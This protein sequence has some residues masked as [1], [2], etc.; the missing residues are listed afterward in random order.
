MRPASEIDR[1]YVLDLLNELVS[2][3]S[4]N[5]TLGR[6][7]GEAA[8][9][10]LLR[11]RLNSVGGLDVRA[12]PVADG[13]SNVIAILRGSGGG[14]SLILNGHM[15]TVGVDGMT[16][17]PFKPFIQNGWMHGRGACDMKGAL[18]AMMGTVKSLVDSGIKLRGNLIF[19][20]VVDEEYQSIGIRKLVQEYK[21]DAAIVGEPTDMRVATAHKGFVWIEIEV[22]GKAAHGSVPEKGVD[23][24]AHAAKIMSA[25][26]KLQPELES[27]VHP[28]LGTPNMHA[29]TV[30][31]GTD[32]SIIPDRCTLRL[33]RRTIPGETASS[34]MT[35]IEQILK[36][37]KHETPNFSAT[38][39]SPFDR[40]PLETA[41]SEGIVQTAQR[42]LAANVGTRVP[43]IGVPYWTDAALLSSMGSIPTC[44][45]GPGDIGVAHSANEYVNLDDVLTSARVYRE[46]IQEY[47]S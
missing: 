23:A 12:Q 34:V 47:C 18:A 25:I 28:L 22:K 10:S 24:I 13:R 46:I 43:V 8:I 40:A 27:R 19:T 36:A 41:D 15:D 38:A 32:W 1:S 30:Q 16:I 35:E 11:D 39:H 14:R 37:I 42:V 4:V 5:P 26:E 33:E 7:P 20:A 2:T 29:A 17:D 6:G 45:L 3:N 31:G 21:A 9:A 44:L